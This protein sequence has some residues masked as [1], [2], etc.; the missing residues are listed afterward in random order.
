MAD[1]PVYFE[2]SWSILSS[3]GLVNVLFGLSVVSITGYSPIALVPIIVS[4]AGAIANGL[5]FYA[6][7][8]N[9]NTTATLVAA[10]SAD[11]GWLV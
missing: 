1:I 4:I 9:Y 11:L 5:C 6:F 3:I 8:A 2:G 7:Y 10:I